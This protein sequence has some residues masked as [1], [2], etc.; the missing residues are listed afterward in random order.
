[1]LAIIFYIKLVKVVKLL[2]IRFNIVINLI[3]NIVN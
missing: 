3:K 2:I 1:M